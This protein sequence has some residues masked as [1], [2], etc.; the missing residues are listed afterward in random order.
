VRLTLRGP[1]RAA[2]AW[3]DA[4]SAFEGVFPARTRRLGLAWAVWA[5]AFAT[6]VSAF[7]HGREAYIVVFVVFASGAFTVP[8]LAVGGSAARRAPA[9]YRHGARIFCGAVALTCAVGVGMLAGLGTSWRVANA[10]GP[11]IVAVTGGL[12]VATIVAYVQSSSGWRAPVVDGLDAAM[13]TVLVVAPIALVWGEGVLASAESWFTVPAGVA[14]VAFVFGFHWV[15]TLLVRVGRGTG[16]LA[17][18]ALLFV[19]AGAADAGAQVAQGLS[20]F[21]LPAP[22]LVALHSI[23]AAM[24]LLVPLHLPRA[25]PPGL[26]LLPAHAQVRGGRLAAAVML[27]GLPF[28]AMALWLD[29]RRPAAVPL[30]LGA[31]GALLILGAVRQLATTRETRR[32]YARLERASEQRRRLLADLLQQADDDRHRVAGQLHEQAVSAHSAFVSLA[33][34]LKQEARS[35]AHVLARASTLVGSDLARH[36][37]SLR[38]LLQAIRP[39]ETEGRGSR[40]LGGPVHAFVDALYGDR[41]PPRLTVSA[42]DGIVLDWVRE[43]IV[44]RIVQEAVRNV[45]RHSHATTIDVSIEVADDGVVELRVVDDGIGFVPGPG[46][47]QA[48]GIA[49]MRSFA[50]LAAGEVDIASAPGA[51]T[52][53]VARL[54]D[55]VVA[56]GRVT[57]VA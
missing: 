57:G 47:A 37:G 13:A 30:A 56:S 6:G 42:P 33:G 4:P 14:I 29:A 34:E 48:S 1:A 21:T 52:T 46:A 41:R 19:V 5:A 12:F 54:S 49:A 22:P 10:A 24:V 23:T 16:L 3:L 40:T 15:A 27:A 35:Q 8:G 51:G 7:A 20:G 36:A 32:L 44:L 38:H 39:L 26:G 28:L 53:V 18:F 2:R 45:W 43:T 55:P 11:G 9:A 17:P 31:A 25:A 50:A